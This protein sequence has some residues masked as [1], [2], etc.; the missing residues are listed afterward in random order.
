[1]TIEETLAGLDP[2][3]AA[4]LGRVIALARRLVPD[5]VDGESYGVPALRV[6][7]KALVGVQASA[8]H[9]SV[10]PFSATA[11]D[12]VRADLVG[13]SVT[14]GL[15]RFTVDRPLPES[16]IERLVLARLAEIRFDGAGSEGFS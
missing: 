14:K 13:Y 2:D 3:V 9:L 1:M 5:A 8:R 4:A 6:D 15:I 7:G 10:I 11:L 12:V 16:I